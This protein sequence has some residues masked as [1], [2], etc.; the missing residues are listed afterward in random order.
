MESEPKNFRYLQPEP[1]QFFNFI[2]V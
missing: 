1:E 2:S